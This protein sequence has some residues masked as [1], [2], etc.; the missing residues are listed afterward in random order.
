MPVL[1]GDAVGRD[2]RRDDVLLVIDAP[3]VDDDVALEFLTFSNEALDRE[4]VAACLTDCRAEPTEDTR[5]IV[6]GDVE[7]DRVL[8]CGGQ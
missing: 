5:H 4:N 2:D 6:E 1:E 7:G 3:A 8:R